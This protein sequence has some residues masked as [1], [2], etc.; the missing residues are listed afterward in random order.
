MNSKNREISLDGDKNPV[1]FFRGIEDK[2]SGIFLAAIVVVVL[3]QIVTREIGVIVPFTEE[4]GR[5][6]LIWMV[7]VG[8]SGAIVSN[9]HIGLDFIHNS[10]NPRLKGINSAITKILMIALLVILIWLGMKFAILQHDLGKT[11]SSIDLPM[12]LVA[13][14]LPVGSA[15]G[16]VRLMQL[17]I[18]QFSLGGVAGK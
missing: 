15:M 2:I 16:V 6:L 14:S 1:S 17:L 12:Y 8:V 3:L 13:L 7:F 9:S 10:L 5:Y 11:W 4:L 18:R